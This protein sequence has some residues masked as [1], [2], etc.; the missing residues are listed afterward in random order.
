METHEG[1][2]ANDHGW[3]DK[4]Q[5]CR[6]VD[7]GLPVYRTVREDILSLLSHHVCANLSRHS[8]N[9][10]TALLL[11]GLT[12]SLGVLSTDTGTAACQS[13]T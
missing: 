5:S 11:V 3:G 9:F 12:V 7:F 13:V 1:G 10:S 8:R 6:C 4:E 2:E